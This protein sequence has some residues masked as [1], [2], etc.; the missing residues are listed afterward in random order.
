MSAGHWQSVHIY[1]WSISEFI[2]IL[3]MWEQLVNHSFTAASQN[4]QE[5]LFQV[6]SGLP[7]L[8]AEWWI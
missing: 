8:G 1:E 5:I 6:H 4:L 3:D 2:R 7:L